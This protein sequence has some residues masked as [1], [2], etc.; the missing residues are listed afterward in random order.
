MLENFLLI[1]D[2]FGIIPNNGRTYY[3]V[4]TQRCYRHKQIVYG[5]VDATNDFELM[6][7]ALP[8]FEYG[9]KLATDSRW[10]MSENGT[11]KGRLHSFK[12][13]SFVNI[14]LNAILFW[15]ARLLKKF[16]I[17]SGNATRAVQF[18]Q[19]AQTIP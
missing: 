9:K 11:N 3:S 4:H 12:T 15:N 17:K 6:K 13:G 14:D 8:I 5:L 7:Y 19:E 10:F 1:V 18:E 16:S 2:R